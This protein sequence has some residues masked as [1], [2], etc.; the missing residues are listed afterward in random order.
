M[1]R[2]GSVR[3]SLLT[4]SIPLILTISLAGG[5]SQPVPS[6][7]VNGT[8]TYAGK[9][10]F[11]GSVIVVDS[12]ERSYVGNLSDD[13]TFRVAVDSEG[14]IRVAVKT[15]KLGNA[16][17]VAASGDPDAETGSREATV[18]DKFKSPNV[19]IPG[20]YSSVETSELTFDLATTGGDLGTIQLQ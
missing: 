19:D 14:P 6:V 2:F 4:L 7:L 17:R 13:G 5:C 3:M 18:P 10:V 15:I 11:P 20:K 1:K 16:G 9:P 8:V 12:E